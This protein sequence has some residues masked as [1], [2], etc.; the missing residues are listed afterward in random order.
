MVLGPLFDLLL[1]RNA[2]SAGID[3]PA[4]P[5]MRELA[6]ALT[7]WTGWMQWIPE[8]R[9]DDF[10]IDVGHHRFNGPPDDSGNDRSFIHNDD[11][12]LALGVQPGE[13]FGAMFVPR[14]EIDAPNLLG[15]AIG[16]KQRGRRQFKELTRF[17]EVKPLSELGPVTSRQLRFVAGGEDSSCVFTRR[18]RLEQ[19]P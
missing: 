15:L 7:E 17:P 8:H 10:S 12:A 16:M 11:D 9:P 18:D 1:V 2:D 5:P 3:V 4:P 13:G 6:E 14:Q 19:N